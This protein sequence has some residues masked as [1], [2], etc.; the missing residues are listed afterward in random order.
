MIWNT[1]KMNRLLYAFV[2]VA[3]LLFLAPTAKAQ[4]TYTAASCNMSDVATAVANENAH[5]VNGDTISIPAGN[6]AWTGTLSS[7][8]KVSVTIQGAGAQNS[9]SYNSAITP[10]NSIT[11]ADSTI[12]ID[13][14]TSSASPIW[15]IG[16]AAGT[17]LR[18]TGI[19]IAQSSS[20]ANES[21]GVVTFS[22]PWTA[23]LRVDHSHLTLNSGAGGFG[24]YGALI[25]VADHNYYQMSTPIGA[26]NSNDIRAYN[27]AG[28]NNVSDPNGYGDGSWADSEHWGTNLFIFAEDSYFSGGG[29]GDCYDGGRSVVR[30]STVVNNQGF[31]S[32]GLS[33]GANRGCRAQEFYNVYFTATYPAYGQ[34]GHPN[35]GG[36]LA[37]GITT[38]GNEV[39]T[40]ASSQMER[41]LTNEGQ[42]ATEVSPAPNGW[43]YCG[44]KYSTGT[45]STTSGS[46]AVTGT[47]FSS[48]WPMPAPLWIP[49]AVCPNYNYSG[50]TGSSCAVSSVASSTPLLKAAAGASVSGVTWTIGSP[51]DGGQA[52]TGYPCLDSPGRGKADLLNSQNFP[53]RLDTV[54]KSITWP[55]QVLSPMYFWDNTLG[56][57][58]SAVVFSD[59]TGTLAANRDY[60]V[61]LGTRGQS[62]SNCT[63]P[64]GCNITVGI[65]QTN[66]A[67]V[68]GS[69][70]CP[71]ATDPMTGNPAPGVGWWDTASNTLYDCS[72]TNTWSVYYTP[73]TYPHPLTTGG[74]TGASVNPPTGLVATVQ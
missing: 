73:Y 35:S 37:W 22:G 49:G 42:N 51:W 27:G 11:D 1:D 15:N 36:M 52:D 29:I 6:C 20:A 65:N 25:G 12:I 39:S 50:T 33:G 30:Y 9:T 31:Y 61:Q 56:A 70:S 47:N 72:A 59:G 41:I 5:A 58:N 28:W 13:G 23:Q 21:N 4:S 2:S 67:P 17:T 14:I 54:T 38:A 63:A 69:D 8:F 44:T 53:N 32:H 7:S 68:S 62:G 10:P 66:R 18:F 16:I 57:T 26:A 45:A 48:S 46:T 40:V 74:T 43:G 19:A 55:N 71:A 3:F 34:I 64:S 60:F 24:V